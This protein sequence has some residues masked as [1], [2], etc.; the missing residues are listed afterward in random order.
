[1]VKL[2]QPVSISPCICEKGKGRMALD[3]SCLNPHSG[4]M[5][6]SKSSELLTRIQH[7]E[8]EVAD[9]E[10]DLQRYRSEIG[11]LN[12]RL[13]GLIEKLHQELRLAHEIQKYL[14]P[15]EFPNLQG[16]EFSSKFLPSSISG[17]DYFDIFEHNDKLRFGVVV[18][19]ASGHAM[20]ALLLSILLKLTGQMEARQGAQPD[21]ILSSICKDILSQSVEGDRADIF[22][23][24]MD[25]RSFTLHYSLVGDITVLYQNSQ[26]REVEV[27]ATG[28]TALSSE[29]DETITMNSLQMNPKDRLV[30]VTQG[31][32]STRN[33]EGE[34]FGVER[35][36]P[37][38]G[39]HPKQGVHELRNA[40]FHSVE[41]HRGGQELQRDQTAIVIEVKERVIKL[42]GSPD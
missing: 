33:L 38:L 25:R 26:S 5:S 16:F 2:F 32:T 20:S 8:K 40:I 17:G 18:S 1:M 24:L 12:S 27:L 41:Q 7:L 14:V 37:I 39:N 22:Y 19:S 4:N 15:T 30:I 23:S 9:R 10:A 21:R 36:I 29:F 13:E 35:L 11:Q 6:D 42:A 34:E 3:R 31:I 28:N